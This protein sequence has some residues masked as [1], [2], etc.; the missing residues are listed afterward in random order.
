MKAAVLEEYRKFSRDEVAIPE[1]NK[2]EV[3]IKVEYAGI[4]GSDMHIFN[5]DF[6]PRT[7]APMIPGNEF[8]GTIEEIGKDVL[9]FNKG[10]RI[11]VDPS[12]G[13]ENARLVNRDIIRHVYH[14][15]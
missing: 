14:L 5:R 13:V 15:N 3:L 7:R 11:S 8:T 9:N 1:S 4:Y 10:D 12:S 6:H 2:N